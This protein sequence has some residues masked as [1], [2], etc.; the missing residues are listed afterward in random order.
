LDDLAS[1]DPTL[2]QGLIFLKHYT[3]DLEDLA[4]NFTVAIEGQ[5]LVHVHLVLG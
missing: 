3:G 4:L 2:Y 5:E 1:L